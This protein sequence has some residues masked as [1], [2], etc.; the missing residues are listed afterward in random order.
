MPTLY[1]G[2]I[3][4]PTNL[5]NDRIGVVGAAFATTTETMIKTTTPSGSISA[6]IS[7]SG[8]TS[9]VATRTSPSS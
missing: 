3:L 2:V 6:T 8:A 9:S 5:T 4:F 7:R 1:S